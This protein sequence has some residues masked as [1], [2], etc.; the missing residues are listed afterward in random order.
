MKH[1]EQPEAWWHSCDRWLR[2]GLGCP[3]GDMDTAFKPEGEAPDEEFEFGNPKREPAILPPGKRQST[4]EN[5]GFH[6]G[7]NKAGV[8]H[9]R[10]VVGERDF[11]RLPE[12]VAPGAR[13]IEDAVLDPETVG[14]FNRVGAMKNSSNAGQAIDAV[15]RV[16]VPVESAR[17]INAVSSP[18]RG[19]SE[20]GRASNPISQAVAANANRHT[21]RFERGT[22]S[23]RQRTQAK[24]NQSTLLSAAGATAAAATSG[25]RGGQLGP[26]SAT[27]ELRSTAAISEALAAS[28]VRRRR[29]S[30]G[31]R[32][33]NAAVEEAE[34]LVRPGA[35]ER[36]GSVRGEGN[37]H[38][39]S[40]RIPR[41]VG[42]A[43]AT[44]GAVGF[45]I[46]AIRSGSPA[47]GGFHKK[48]VF[49]TQTPK[50]AP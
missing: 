49:G 12:L 4:A 18:S 37:R 22:S 30:S 21:E 27:A 11:H 1:Y 10:A 24:V 16:P 26:P 5:K 15:A 28:A 7:P 19:T 50:F 14:E 17:N 43:A 29:G 23:Y 41:A 13:E 39:D 34:R 40:Q 9:G 33:K 48:S 42:A 8:P 45:G 3:L 35:R 36:E 32:E 20:R 31:R 46:R 44:A 25:G 6:Y 47:G 38:P 2:N